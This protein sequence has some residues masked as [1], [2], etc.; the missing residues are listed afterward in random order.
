M[1]GQQ[2]HEKVLSITNHQENAHQNC[3]EISP[4]SCQNGFYQKEKKQVLAKL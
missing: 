2:L 4:H 3:N 1:D